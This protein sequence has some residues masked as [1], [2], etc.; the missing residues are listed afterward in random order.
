MVMVD[1]DHVGGGLNTFD[2]HEVR[3]FTVSGE[4]G[5]FVEATGRVV[6]E[7]T[8]AVSGEGV[9][10]PVEIRY[11]WANNPVVNLESREGLP[12]TPFR[13]RLD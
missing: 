13:V 11:G 6:D 7:D 3:G 2:V 9:Q 8:V 10:R 1:F 5:K 4:D 12:A